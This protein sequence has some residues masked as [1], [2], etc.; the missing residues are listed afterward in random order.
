[1]EFKLRSKPQT[2]KIMSKRYLANTIFIFCFFF[3]ADAQVPSNFNK[4]SGA[5]QPIGSVSVYPN[6]TDLVNTNN[7]NF[8]RT[9]IAQKPLQDPNDINIGTIYNASAATQY[10]DGLGRPLQEVARMAVGDPG[11]D[12]VTVHAYDD[13]GRESFKYL[14]FDFF[15]YGNQGKLKTI[16]YSALISRFN[17]FYPGDAPYSQTKFDNSPLNRPTMVLQPGTSWVGSGRGLSIEYSTN[18]SQF[19]PKWSIGFAGG[20]IPQYVGTYNAA[21]LYVTA[22]RDEDGHVKMLYKDKEGH[23]ICQLT[24]IAF[25]S[26]ALGYVPSDWIRTFY[27]YDN[28][29][30]LRFVMSPEAVKAV[31]PLNWQTDPW[32]ISQTVADGLCYQFTYDQ[33]GRVVERKIPGK[34][35]EYYVYDSRDRVVLYQN[36]T[37]RNY[38]N[39]PFFIGGCNNYWEFTIY[40]G[41]NRVLE[42]GLWNNCPSNTRQQLAAMV[43]DANNYASTSLMYFLK[44]NNLS[45]YPGQIDNAQIY[46]YTYYDNY[47]QLG[48]SFNP[49]YV[50]QLTGT[51]P[52]AAYPTA[53]NSTIGL[54]TGTKVRVLTNNSNLAEWITTS[55]F[56]DDQGRLIQ[57]QKNNI[58]NGTDVETFQ[59]DFS[60]TLVSSVLAHNNPVAISIDPL[61]PSAYQNQTI[62]KKYTKT[63]VSDQITKLEQNIN[64]TGWH[65]IYAN[66]YDHFNRLK[67]KSLGPTSN[68][69]KYNING[70]MA[71]INQTYLDKIAYPSMPDDKFFAE[72]ICYDYGFYNQLYNGNISGTI[73]RN[74]GNSTP[75]SYAYTYDNADRLTY[76]NFNEYINTG[77]WYWGMGNTDLTASNINYDN[78]GN[79]LT[80]NQKGPGASGP[81][82]MDVLSYT[83]RPFTNIL[84]GISDVGSVT[85]NPDFK[86][87]GAHNSVGDYNYDANGNLIFDNNKHITAVNNYID[88]PVQITQGGNSISKTYDALGT[89]LQEDFIINGVPSNRYFIGNLLYENDT[90]KSIENEEGRCRPILGNTTNV[91]SFTYDY[92]V[93]D[94]NGNVRTVINA[95]AYSG[96]GYNTSP[97]G[98]QLLRQYK[99]GMEVSSANTES[100]IWSHLDDVRGDKPGSTN[101]VDTK[102]AELN[103]KDTKTQIGPAIMLRV[104]AGDQISISAN[105][106]YDAIGTDKLVDPNDIVTSLIEAL[107]GGSSHTGIPTSEVPENL[108]V[109]NNTFGSGEFPAFYSQLI[110]NNYDDSRPA[111]FINYVLFDENMRVISDNSGVIQ[112]SGPSSQWNSLGTNGNVVCYK[113]GF[114]G[115]WA[116]TLVNSPSYLDNVDVTLY[117]GNLLEENHYYPYGLTLTSST[118]TYNEKNSYKF[119]DKR[120]QSELDL[121]WYNFGGRQYDM[122]I[123]RWTGIDKLATNYTAFSPFVYSVNN[124]VF[125]V[126]HDGNKVYRY[127]GNK[128]RTL[129][130]GESFVQSSWT[131]NKD[132]NSFALQTGSNYGV[133]LEY[134]VGGQMPAG[135]LGTTVMMFKVGGRWLDRNDYLKASNTCND[136]T[137]VTDFKLDIRINPDISRSDL[138]GVTYAHEL[139]MHAEEMGNIISAGRKAGQ[140]NIDIYRSLINLDPDNQHKDIVNMNSD[141]NKSMN[142]LVDYLHTS[143]INNEGTEQ[144]FNA[145]EKGAV[146]SKIAEMGFADAA[147]KSQANTFILLLNQIVQTY[148][149]TS[150]ERQQATREFFKHRFTQPVN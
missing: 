86:D 43:T 128:S 149:F 3:R 41:L 91:A 59:Y 27:I 29:G 143:K 49:V 130:D 14:N 12:L 139:E 56:Y 106:Y 13:M 22:T 78:N 65:T 89:L 18:P 69:Y 35:V 39:V 81:V 44:Q 54:V 24:R 101:P 96:S 82:D 150:A 98:Q 107:S 55:N 31:T 33:R 17:V 70:W 4:P 71:G 113:T 20:D 58:K 76:A 30:N 42:T 90:L 100:L 61:N 72:N 135:D 68:E 104:M 1:M 138:A 109:I 111:T 25:S 2:P 120:L 119:I 87:D 9:Y 28:M 99:T 142:E 7:R 74:S 66:T 84:D 129:Q 105:S 40:D 136:G 8:V 116:S 131:Y 79:I 57:Q 64:N 73:W 26:P 102:A 77:A 19:I 85:S 148:D 122:Q 141:Y 67:T 147:N 38:V 127:D 117:R 115:I 126:D 6:L 50:S 63:Y 134:H 114:I 112:I 36:G 62:V 121:N 16:P 94:H 83:Y 47:S 88:K 93:K 60:G 133:N 32:V 37:L 10:I 146:N 110:N 80:M 52:Y 15:D 145:G 48:S 118:G 75:R 45:T 46:T 34:D 97:Y 125:Y 11:I 53:T 92:Y 95:E 23:T 137:D 124:P 132:Y 5:T 140:K 103:A 51:A 123:G 144:L 108:D 21:E